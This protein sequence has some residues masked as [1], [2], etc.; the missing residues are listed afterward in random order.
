MQL[1]AWLTELKQELQSEEVA[2]SLE[3]GERLL[4]QFAAQRDSTLDA[5]AS[6][7]GEGKALL[8]EIKANANQEADATGSVASVSSA[9]E[10]LA[11]QRDE[12]GDLWST[13]KLRLDLCL[14]LRVF[15]RDALELSAQYEMWETQL[16]NGDIPRDL[17]ETEV[18]LRNLNEHVSHI[19]T[20][21][22]EVA[23]RGRDLLQT[24][25][26]SGIN[27]MADTQYNGQTRVQVLLDY[28]QE[29]QMD[30]EDLGAIRRIK[31][32]QCVQ[33]CQFENDAN[34]VIRWI[35]SAEEMLTAGFSIPGSLADAEQLKKEH[36]Q[37][38][39]AIEK[40]HASAVHVR[41]R[42]ETLL[43]NN[44][45][46]PDAVREIADGV[47]SRWQ[48]LVTRAEERHKLV[49][50]SLNFYKTAEQVCSVLDSLE[51]EYKREDVDWLSLGGSRSGS[52]QQDRVSLITQLINK[53]QE[54]KEAFLKACTL[55]RRTAETFLKYSNR[56]LQYFNQQSTF[57]GPDAK[58]KGM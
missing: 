6:T 1:T 8:E 27:L 44:H 18:Q 50:A 5:C 19:Q 58:V 26:R 46:D 39:T 11:A 4:E 13:R 38:Q 48:Q 51:R 53:H 43:T 22:Y 3:G 16:Q 12:L 49:T 34:Q 31:L 24:F 42:A 21:T 35:H 20:A 23:Q 9:L 14:Q 15:E 45:Y 25:E 54:Q 7:I 52:D 33:L 36:E 30:I 57:R 47:T 56:S 28:I 29:R 10:K 32:E 40:T 55:A 2:D 17:K 41:Q 37:F